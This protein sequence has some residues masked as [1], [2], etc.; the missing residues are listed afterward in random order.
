[1]GYLEALAI[2]ESERADALQLAQ[3]VDGE[4]RRA[5]H[6]RRAEALAIAIKALMGVW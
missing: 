3:I 4:A 1:M 5:M 6:R 2:L